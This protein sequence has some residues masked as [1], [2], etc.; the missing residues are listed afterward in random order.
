[1]T[2]YLYTLIFVLLFF[3]AK[4]QYIPNSS[5][6]FQFASIYNPAFTGVEDFMDVKVGYRVMTGLGPTAPK[7]I[8]IA[9]NFRLKQ[10]LDLSTHALRTGSS[11]LND[12]NFLPKGKRIIHGLGVNLFNEKVGLFDRLGGG[13]RYS[14]NYPITSKIRLAAGV[15][16]VVENLKLDANAIY[17]G[18][19]GDLEDPLY[20]YL[21]LNGSNQMEINTRAGLLLYSN[22][23]YI[24]VS[25]L[26]LFNTAIQSSELEDME[27]YYRGVVQTGVSLAVSDDLVLK[28]SVVAIMRMDNEM[29]IDYNVKAQIKEKLWTGITYRDIKASVVSVGFDFNHLTGVAY[30]YEMS[31]GDF[32]QFNDGSHE[33]VLCFRFN[34]FKRSIPN[35]W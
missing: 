12:P 19:D 4:G 32:K 25:Y 13:V 17:L 20:K 1:M 27:P 29:M 10:P 3:V 18:K 34:N 6:A 22:K 7:V 31:M 21:L 9:A 28:P 16:A 23:F 2:R 24:G 30:S 11:K 15:S 33:V 8:N 5:Q 14:F 26:P 35:T